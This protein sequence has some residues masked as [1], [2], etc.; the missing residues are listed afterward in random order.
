MTRSEAIQMLNQTKQ[1]FSTHTDLFEHLMSQ[2]NNVFR[3][4]E[5]MLGNSKKGSMIS[6]IFPSMRNLT[7]WEF[8]KIGL[9]GFLIVIL[10][11]LMLNSIHT[12]GVIF[13][14]SGFVYIVAR[15]RKAGSLKKQQVI[16]ESEENIPV[17][18]SELFELYDS[19]PLKD[20]IAFS[21]CYYQVTD[22]LLYFLNTG[23]SDNIKDAAKE[24]MRESETMKR[25]GIQDL[26]IGDILD[27]LGN[28]YSRRDVSIKV[29]AKE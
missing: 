4:N 18:M 24:V 9:P 1:Y 13:I 15:A 23:I 26:T 20:E 8:F 12:I 22:R 27:N 29:P 17:L 16:N 2:E 21:L 11:M 14:L 28:V 10:G 7:N 6:A 19:F 5:N 25:N 3:A